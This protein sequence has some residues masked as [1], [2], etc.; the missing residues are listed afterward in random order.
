MMLGDPIMET[1]RRNLHIGIIAPNR[2]VL[3]SNTLVSGINILVT[4]SVDDLVIVNTWFRVVNSII[5]DLTV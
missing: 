2:V 3:F 5:E 1:L 4:T